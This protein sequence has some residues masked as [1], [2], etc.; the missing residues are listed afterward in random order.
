MQVYQ[1]PV[2]NEYNVTP[3]EFAEYILKMNEYGIRIVGGCCGT[4]PDFIKATVKILSKVKPVIVRKEIPTAICSPT[5]T[6]VVDQPRIIGERINPTGKKLFKQAL[7]DN[8]IDYILGQAIEQVQV[9]QIFL[10]LM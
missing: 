5:S 10:M 4:T 2:T 8:N 6:V 9:V 7:I 1:N 3:D